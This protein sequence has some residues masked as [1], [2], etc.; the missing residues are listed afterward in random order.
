MSVYGVESFLFQLG[1]GE[2]LRKAYRE[3]R[4]AALSGYD[5]SEEERVA[6]EAIDLRWLIEYGVHPILL[7]R[8]NLTGEIPSREAY[9]KL[10]RGAPAQ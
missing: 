2:A 8:F 1:Q 3:D 6:V 9:L 7:L 10:L 4:G 5:I